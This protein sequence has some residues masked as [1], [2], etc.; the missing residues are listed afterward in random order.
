MLEKV[1]FL[2]TGAGMPTKERNVSSLA[3]IFNKSGNFW[4]FDCG[5]GTQQ[6]LHRAG[7][8]LSKLKSIFISHLHGDHIF[9]LPGLLASRG[10]MG[11]KKD[12]DI[13]G[14]IGLENYLNKCFEYSKTFI[15]Y[16]YKIYHIERDKYFKKNILCK[17]GVNT[18][19]CALLNHQIDCFGYLIME[20]NIKRNIITKELEKLGINPGPIYSEI[21]KNSQI[22]LGDGSVLKTDV[23][24]KKSRKVKKI[25]YCCDTMFSDNA[26]VLARRADLLIHEATFASNEREKATKSFHSTI[27]DAIKVAKHARARKLAL[28]HISPRYKR[29]TKSEEGI[30]VLK[31][32]LEEIGM[33]NSEIEII[34]A[35]DLLEIK[36]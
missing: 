12:I 30:D 18:I 35:E 34:L 7:L 8:K 6:Q 27:E 3:V 19:Y 21:K 26:I 36:I 14:P 13:F 5:E 16:N 9:G 32:Y 15:P 24:I 23:F 29:G 10:L 1:I 28:T 33:G 17:I 2:G 11:I 4:L 20:E 25:C 31:N 22:T